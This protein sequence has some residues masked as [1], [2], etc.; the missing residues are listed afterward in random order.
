MPVLPGRRLLASRRVDSRHSPL[1][2]IP[3]DPQS[4]EVSI[5]HSPG[6]RSVP[7][8]GWQPSR[9]RMVLAGVTTPSWRT[10]CA[11]SA[12]ASAAPAA[13]GGGGGQGTV[14]NPSGRVALDAW[15][16]CPSS[17]KT[18]CSLPPEAAASSP[19]P[20]R[21]WGAAIGCK[22]PRRA[23]LLCCPLTLVAPLL[24]G[25]LLDLVVQLEDA[26]AVPLDLVWD[27]LALL[28]LQ[29]VLDS[30]R[31][32]QEGE[33]GGRQRTGWCV[34]LPQPGAPHRRPHACSAAPP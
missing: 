30:S 28:R 17:V 24:L 6:S 14:R 22:L 2:R 20:P 7:G 26:L 13:G 29:G 9:P 11:L 33:G 1:Q 19:H 18:L 32:G 8:S 5:S 12:A 21:P 15:G 27:V 16:R 10:T 34:P 3:L 4:S 31:G 23:A 25:N